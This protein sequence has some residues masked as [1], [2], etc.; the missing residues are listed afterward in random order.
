M[1][2]RCDG[3][4]E[5]RDV[6]AKALRAAANVL[7]ERGMDDLSLRAIAEAA[8]MAVTS[9]YYYF[10]NKEE[11]LHDLAIQGFE[12][13]R[14]DILEQQANPEFQGPIRGAARG[15]M[16]FVEARRELFILMF[17]EPL[18]ARHQLL[19]D[20][21][22]SAFQAFDAAVRADDRL[23]VSKRADV[24][25]ALWTLGRGVAA[26]IASHPNGKLPEGLRDKLWD[27]VNFLIDR[28]E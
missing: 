11:L 14:R 7:A 9:M 15:Y 1:R 23:P 2:V 17:S 20:A 22:S 19:R 4:R 13:L 24:A 21:E 28:P 10:R 18:L 3:P 25:L 27:G 16:A 12:D 8:G 6:K 5:G 26:L